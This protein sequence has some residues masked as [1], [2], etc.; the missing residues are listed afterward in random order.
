MSTMKVTQLYELIS[1]V[2]PTSP[3]FL[4]EHKKN[5]EQIK[6]NINEAFDAESDLQQLGRVIQSTYRLGGMN[7]HF[8]NYLASLYGKAAKLLKDL[9]KALSKASP[10]LK[11][12]YEPLVLPKAAEV[13]AMMKED[14]E[15]YLPIATLELTQAQ[16]RNPNWKNWDENYHDWETINRKFK[17]A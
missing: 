13:Y 6:K 17:E 4:F 8:Y 16:H 10:E 11:A 1:G 9:E 12:Y 5:Y 14:F 2:H 7:F 3:H 15:N